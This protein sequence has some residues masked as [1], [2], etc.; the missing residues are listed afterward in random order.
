MDKFKE[1]ID[2]IRSIYKTEN[3]IPLHEPLFAGNEK[4]Y[5]EE[6]ID[7][8]FVSSVG[9]FVD[10]FERQI[11]EY[12]GAKKAIAVV[13]GTSA[14]HAALTMVGVRNGDEVITQPLT[15]IATC[16]AISY[17][18]ASPVFLDVDLDT[19]GL[20][21]VSLNTFLKKN[22][23]K[24]NGIVINKVTGEKI[25]ACVPMHSLGH[26]V[27][28]QEICDIC[29]KWGIPLIEDA[30]ESLGSF[31]DKKHTGLFGKCGILSF[32]GN[33][34]ITTGGGGMIITNDEDFGTLAKHI[35]TTAKIPH[36]WEFIHDLIGFNYRMPNIN[37][38]LG[39]A[40]MEKLSEYVSI[41]RE[42]AE[43]Y[44]LF[45]ENTD[46]DF[47]TERN[48]TRAN[49]WLNTL[50][51][52]NIKERNYFLEYTNNNGV[53]TRPLWTLMNN[54]K[55]YKNCFQVD[56]KNSITLEQQIVNIPSS[57]IKG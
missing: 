56:L 35:T 49:Y 41:K 4:N 18:G 47:I 15:F 42:I 52:K 10:Q 33:K 20:S 38:A 2:F 27:R 37:A 32:N 6:C 51:F 40:Q 34:I 39:C 1:I 19:M 3:F 9:K 21:P 11:A 17:C 25:A 53:M 43:K 12:T 5:L 28:I 45:F 31:T 48:C 50:K 24:K 8:S 36:R 14:L 30:A 23:N 46:I 57:V 7:S 55:M 22:C 16:N 26:P 44:K 13:N 54:L 29:E